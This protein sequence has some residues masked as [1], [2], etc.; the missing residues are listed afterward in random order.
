[1]L[2]TLMRP[3]SC[4]SDGNSDA[5]L[6]TM[7]TVA[8]GGGTDFWSGALA[9]PFLSYYVITSALV[10]SD[11][12]TN[13]SEDTI[14]N[15]TEYSGYVRFAPSYATCMKICQSMI[16]AG[17]MGG[18]TTAPAIPVLLPII[19]VCVFA[20][21]LPSL[22]H[23]VSHTERLC[24]VPSVL[25]IRSGSYLC[26]TWTAI[27]CLIRS[28]AP[29]PEWLDNT[30]I[31]GSEGVVYI[32]WG[33]IYML[34]CI[35][36]Y[37]IEKTMYTTWQQYLQEEGLNDAITSLISTFDTA[38]IET[39][40]STT[41]TTNNSNSSG[42]GNS[43]V[44]TVLTQLKERVSYC[45]SIQDISLLLLQL[46]DM[47]V[48]D[49]LNDNFLSQRKLWIKVLSDASNSHNYTNTTDNMTT[50]RNTQY[51]QRQSLLLADNYD[52]I[53]RHRSGHQKQQQPNQAVVVSSVLSGSSGSNKVRMMKFQVILDQSLFLQTSLRNPLVTTNLSLDTLTILLSY[54]L[55][56]DVVWYIFGYL[57]KTNDLR[58][59]L[60]R[61]HTSDDDIKRNKP[62]PGRSYTVLPEPK[63]KDCSGK[64]YCDQMLR[65]AASLLRYKSE[66]ITAEAKK[67]IS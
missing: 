19:F 14:E 18:F 2:T 24:N 59:I 43:S 60:I 31:F 63:L 30:V 27:V 58:S 61:P 36:C 35:H 62:Y 57:I 1:M 15:L 38:L 12:S 56:R 6:S 51:H 47:I 42:M 45:R 46:E 67:V 4:V 54:H 37:R 11:S 53:E 52:D 64:N 5:V 48:I 50:Q 23:C 32:G 17:C 9:F 21:L 16:V 28:F 3:W 10:Y 41:T 25:P 13:V 34:T 29:S 22:L 44:N 8:C 26:V 20:T 66:K 7:N 55:P 40:I 49:S 33:I 39:S 65:Y